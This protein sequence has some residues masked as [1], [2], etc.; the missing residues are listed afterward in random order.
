MKK[1]N[2]YACIRDQQMCSETF[3]AEKDIPRTK[4]STTPMAVRSASIDQ[5][6]PDTPFFVSHADWESQNRDYTS[7][8]RD[9]TISYIHWLGF[10]PKRPLATQFY[11]FSPPAMRLYPISPAIAFDS[12]RLRSPVTCPTDF[13]FPPPERASSRLSFKRSGTL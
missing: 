11:V 3:L 9:R 4:L 12:V 2:P 7:R 5:Y 13:L 10:M 8:L 1:S 6:P